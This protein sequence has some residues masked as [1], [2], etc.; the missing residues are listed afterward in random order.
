[1][2]SR[3]EFRDNRLYVD[4][5]AALLTSVGEFVAVLSIFLYDFDL[6]RQRISS[7]SGVLQL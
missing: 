4:Y 2:Q 1:M 3:R 5:S 7:F 6:I